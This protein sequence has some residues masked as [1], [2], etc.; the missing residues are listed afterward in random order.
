[1]TPAPTPRAAGLLVP[2]SSMPTTASWGIGEIGDLPAMARWLCRAGQSLLQLLPINE[3]APG[4]NSPY[5]ATSAMAIDPIFIALRDV[6]EFIAEGAERSLSA[7]DRDAVARARLAPRVQYAVVRSLKNGA[8]GAA[9]ARFRDAEWRRDTPRARDLTRFIGEQAWWLED[10]ALFRALHAREGE[11]AW[12]SW[13]PALRAHDAG[14]VAAARRDLQDQILFFQ[15]LQWLADSQ[16]RAARA[17]SGGVA[18]FGDLPFMVDVDSADVWANQHLFDLEGSVGVP[19]DAFSDTGQNWGLPVYRWDVMARTGY[20]WLHQR[21][22]RAADLYDGYRVDHVVGFYR[23]YVFPREGRGK[24][25][26]TPADEA[27]QLALGEQVLRVLGDARAQILAEDLGTV[28]DFVRASL[29]HLGVPGYRVLRWEREWN[30]KDQ[31]F[32]DPS[33]YPSA[34]VATSGTHDTEAMAAWWD[35]A[36]AAERRGLGE[37]PFLAARLGSGFDFEHAPYGP[38]L[39]DALLEMLF[40]SGSALL[41]LPV[42]DVFGWRER[43]NVPAAVSEEN[44]TYRLPWP[45]DTL[46]HQPPAEE[47][48]EALANWARTHGRSGPAR[49]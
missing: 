32:R 36:S 11:R 48:A 7:A 33:A 29:A 15:Y 25:Y 21:G 23:T 2:L 24:P 41:M 5:S 22:R 34:S 3:M 17:R 10:Y 45:V 30:T 18:F 43:I 20:E 37:L 26:F 16:W 47:R 40:A 1:M 19:P 31:P 14:A 28:P 42:L 38:A 27:D 13:D 39:R 8:F 46:H 4:E 12:T 35:L 6:E 44:W 9:F 49:Q